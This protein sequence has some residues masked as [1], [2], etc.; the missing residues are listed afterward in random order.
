MSLNATG[1]TWQPTWNSLG[2]TT[3]VAFGIKSNGV[4][5]V[6]NSSVD[7][8]SE[9]DI[10]GKTLAELIADGQAKVVAEHPNLI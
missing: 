10:M 5:A 6:Y 3:T 1:V 9:G 8:A 7:Y 2:F 4:A